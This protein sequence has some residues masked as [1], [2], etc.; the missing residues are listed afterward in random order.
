MMGVEQMVRRNSAWPKAYRRW[1]DRERDELVRLLLQ[2]NL[3]FDHIAS[4]LGRSPRALK[5][6]FCNIIEAVDWS[7]LSPAVR[8]PPVNPSPDDIANDILAMIRAGSTPVDIMD[9]YPYFY[10][11]HFQAII[12]MWELANRRTWRSNR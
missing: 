3:I 1:N 5:L 6:E 11:L 2:D 8:A 7:N 4:I 9:K 10:I 12:S